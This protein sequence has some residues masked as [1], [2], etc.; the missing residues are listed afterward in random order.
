MVPQ[1]VPEQPLPL[2]VHVT[3]KLPGSLLII[4]VN[5]RVVLTSTP[6][7]PVGVMLSWMSE[8]MVTAAVAD[9]VLSVTEVAV[10]VTLFGL[11]RMAGAV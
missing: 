9:L 11:G 3:P 5:C 8:V 7:K 4:A 1:A 6:T 2:T 10:T